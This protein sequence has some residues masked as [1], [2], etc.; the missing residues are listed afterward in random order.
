MMK[1][2]NL[3]MLA[4][5]VAVV[6]VGGT[7]MAIECPP[8]LTTPF[9][10]MPPAPGNFN[11]CAALDTIYCS[12]FP[13]AFLA[14]EIEMFMGL[15]LCET[16]DINGTPIE[17]EPYVLP[18]GMWDAYELRVIANVLNDPAYNQ[19]GLTH[20]EVLAGFNSNYALVKSLVEAALEAEG[21][22]LL[23]NALAPWLISSLS[24][25]LSGYALIGD[26]N[27]L[28]ALD[29]LMGLLEGLGIPP[30]DPNDFATFGAW[31]GSESDADGDGCTN[32]E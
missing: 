18:N 21:Y 10:P 9:T 7:A 12:L 14:P 23:V 13:V 15:V 27:S 19:K 8:Q 5:A 22:L 17:E 26:E 24:Y 4:I 29:A 32:R 31:F 2:K 11:F 6:L 3:S 30:P 28:L 25:A 1:K 16:A 20:A